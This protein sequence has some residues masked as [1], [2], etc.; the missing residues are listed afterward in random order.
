MPKG[1]TA[2]AVVTMR[3]MLDSG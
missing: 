3:E 1:E 2:M